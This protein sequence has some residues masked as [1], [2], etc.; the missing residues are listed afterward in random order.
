MSQRYSPNGAK[1]GWNCPRCANERSKAYRLS[2]PDAYLNNKLWTFYRIRLSDIRHL[3]V[4]QNGR[5]AACGKTPDVG[6]RGTFAGTGLVIDHDH[7]CCP[8][9][10][11]E[12]ICGKCIRGLICP[13]CNVA[14]GMVREDPAR[15]RALADY[16]EH[17]VTSKPAPRARPESA[18]TMI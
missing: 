15:L 1:R 17:H 5:C 8:W 13:G 3:L 10:P 12:R 6:T 14:L 7:A 16:V 18:V 2:A 4:K 9:Q 11:R